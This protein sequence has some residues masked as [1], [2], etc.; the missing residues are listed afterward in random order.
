[1]DTNYELV[2]KANGRLDADMIRLF[3]ESEGLSP[4]VYLE[5]AGQ[6]YGLTVGPLSEAKIYVPKDQVQTAMELLDAM[7]KG[8]IN[9]EP[10]DDEGSQESDTD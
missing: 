2:Y 1:M 4:L 7:E 6:T 5:S 9:L 3:L 8:E 10:L